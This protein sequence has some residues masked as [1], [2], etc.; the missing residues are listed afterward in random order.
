MTEE[1]V[2]RIGRNEALFRSFNEGIR[3]V[4]AAFQN[5]HEDSFGSGLP[6]ELEIVCEC[7]RHDCEERIRIPREEYE[8]VRRDAHRF[9]VKPGHVFPDIETV[10]DRRGGYEVIEKDEG[11]PK[12]I[13]ERLDPRA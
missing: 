1:R 9:V 12:R 13:A 11:E 10:L 7:G 3:R 6:D 2:E 8:S 4:S 5:D